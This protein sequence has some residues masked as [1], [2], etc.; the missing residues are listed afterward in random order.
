[1]VLS[2]PAAPWG[3]TEVANKA[4]PRRPRI[5][6]HQHSEMYLPTVACD[7]DRMMSTLQLKIDS[8]PSVIASDVNRGD[9]NETHERKN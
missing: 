7:L 9:R 5:R 3:S 2:S 4:E 1:M 8:I 6:K